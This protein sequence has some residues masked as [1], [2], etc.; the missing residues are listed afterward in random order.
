M[1]TGNQPSLASFSA[2]GKEYTAED[3]FTENANGN[4]EGTVEVSKKS[5]MVSATNAI[6]TTVGNG[7]IGTI[8]YK[9]VESDVNGSKPACD[10]TIPVIL[11]ATGTTKTYI[12][13]FVWK[14]DY[15]V[16]YHDTD[17]KVIA[18]QTVEK[19]DAITTLNDGETVTVPSGSKFRG[20]PQP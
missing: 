13:H 3:F 19:G 4:Y 10:V 7:T 20:R 6:T 8:T 12:V 18:K 17:D 14:P 15:S 11:T 9:E 2:Y 1:S 5:D 16:I